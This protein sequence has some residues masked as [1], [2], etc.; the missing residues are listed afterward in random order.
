MNIE[1][2][3]EAAR[4][5]LSDMSLS[6]S[7]AMDIANYFINTVPWSRVINACEDLGIK[8]K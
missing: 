2:K 5:A 4:K 6:R 3:R 1:E 7:G 8:L